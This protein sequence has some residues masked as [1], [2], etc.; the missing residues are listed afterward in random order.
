MRKLVRSNVEICRRLWA[1][2][3]VSF[4]DDY[5]DFTDV[6]LKPRSYLRINRD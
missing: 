3:G 4:K 5:F 6:S 2:E 1:G